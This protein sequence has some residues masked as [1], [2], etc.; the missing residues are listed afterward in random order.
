MLPFYRK[1]FLKHWVNKRFP[2]YIGG[3]RYVFTTVC[4]C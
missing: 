1:Y 4:I 2:T 3:G